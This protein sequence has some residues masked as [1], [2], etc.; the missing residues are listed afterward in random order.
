M[1]NCLV[2]DDEPLALDL[3]EN[4]VS[5]VPYLKLA[6]RFEEPLMALPLIE[7]GNVDLLFLDIKMP[8][9]DGFDVLRWM[10]DHPQC[11]V[12]PT[13]MLSSS[14]YDRDVRLAYELGA[15]AYMM[16]PAD[17]NDLKSMLQAAYDFWARC[18]KPKVLNSK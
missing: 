8:Q 10:R 12:M 7:N 3:L 9:A 15:S 13:M 5:K 17:L 18:V 4:F 1:I 11:S 16:K 14:D 2:I 6:G